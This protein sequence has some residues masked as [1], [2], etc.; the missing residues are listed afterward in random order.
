MVSRGQMVVGI[1][2]QMVGLA[3]ISMAVSILSP[4]TQVWAHPDEDLALVRSELARYQLGGESI[5]EALHT[6]S[7]L[8]G[9]EAGEASREARALRAL[10]ATD[11]L[12]VTHVESH[13]TEIEEPLSEVFGVPRYRLVGHLIGELEAVNSGIYR[14]V[15]QDAIHGLALMDEVDVPLPV[16]W[17]HFRGVR[18]DILILRA[19][20]TGA[21]NVG[22][23]FDPCSRGACAEPWADW[24][25]ATRARVAAL[26]EATSAA[27]RLET[28][29]AE[30][31]PLVVALHDHIAD[32]RARLQSMQIVPAVR[33][34]HEARVAPAG[35]YDP[36]V[37]IDRLAI[38]D[39]HEIRVM[40]SPIIQ[41][42]GTE[43]TPLDPEHHE[44]GV[45]STA[46]P[47]SRPLDDAVDL[48]LG[49]MR[50]GAALALAS[51][52]HA[53]CEPMWDLMRRAREAGAASVVWL[54]RGSDGSVRG[55]QLALV[56]GS[57]AERGDV[58]IRV[59]PG[60]FAIERGEHSILV[61]RH[62]T[63]GGFEA[64][65]LDLNRR[66]HFGITRRVLI[67]YA[68]PAAAD[69]VMRVALELARHRDDVVVAI[70]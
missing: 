45:Y 51:T 9:I 19:I 11:L 50:R 23:A 61:E 31:D 7:D 3:A 59:R 60:Y 27:R 54:R 12:V 17:D 24:D 1:H 16:H 44:I 15:A 6:L 13:W 8:A 29:L 4:P 33:L 14:G 21:A 42:R 25:P 65:L 30:G 26:S 2:R 37:H 39:A 56:D 43:L 63:E 41:V 53:P 55:R 28:A 49:A 69:D 47:A 66:L 70:R 34:A 57:E 48:G 22:A 62:R 32:Y 35:A 58:M 36:P 67:S 20:A 52:E 46:F 38:N 64:D 10:V 40:V 68:G 5:L 18:R